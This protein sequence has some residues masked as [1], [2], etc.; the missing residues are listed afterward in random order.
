[1]LVRVD[2]SS[3]EPLFAQ[4]AAAVRGAIA[5]GEL[6]AGQRLP[7]ARDLAESLGLNIHTVLRGYQ[8][9]RDEG[10][11]ELRRGRGAVVTAQAGDGLA[12]LRA[13]V[14][15]LVDQAQRLGF[16]SDELTHMIR[17]EYR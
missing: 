1:M 8:L 13:T 16:T 11:V 7:G 10:L 3:P 12:R 5:R 4:L 14:H 2:P 17:T 9:L 15:E 6:T